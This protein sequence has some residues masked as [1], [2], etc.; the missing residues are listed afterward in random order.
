MRKMLASK[1][2][3][4]RGLERLDTLKKINQCPF[5]TDR[6]AYEQGKKIDGFIGAKAPA[7]QT[8]LMSKR[9]KQ[10]VR[11]KVLNHDHDFSKPWRN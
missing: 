10:P 3:H 11:H 2:C 9:L 7:H 4:E 8:D 6:I 5:S 1:Q